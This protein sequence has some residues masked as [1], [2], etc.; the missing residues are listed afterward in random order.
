M[1]GYKLSEGSLSRGADQ[2][3]PRT[4][5][6][7]AA[8]HL[9]FMA[10]LLVTCG[11]K[12]AFAQQ[13]ELV[14]IPQP[15]RDA[16][17]R[18]PS[19]EVR[20]KES[21][22]IHEFVDP[23]LILYIDPARSRIVHTKQP[24]TR[25]VITDPTVLDVNQFGP[26]EFELIGR[27]SGETTLSLWFVDQD[28]SESLLRYVVR[29][30]P[31][32][33]EQQRADIEYG[34]LQDRLNELF[35]NSQIQLIPVADKLIVRGQV[36]DSEEAARIIAV[37]S[38]EAID[39]YGGY[40]PGFG[41]AN[42]ARLPGAEDLPSAQVI[43]LLIVPGE[44]QV[45]L[46]VR[47]AELSRSALRELGMDFEIIQDTF[48]IQH[49][50]GGAG[51]LTAIL[52]SG[53]VSLFIRAFSS[54]GYSKILAEPTLVTLSGHTAR[55]LAGGE[56]AVPTAVGIDGIAAAS[57]SFRGF[58]TQL[59][60]TPTVLDKDRIR[61][62]VAPSFSALNQDNSVDGIPGLDTRAVS[63]TVDLREGQW[64]AIAGLI[65]DEQQGSH[66][67][68]P[69]LG[70]IP[71]LGA[72]FGSQKVLRGETELVVLVSPELVH[73]LEAEQ[74]PLM[75]PGMELMDPTDHDFYL[76][77]KIEGRP[78]YAHRSTVWPSYRHRRREANSRAVHEAKAQIKMH[79]MFNRHQKYYLS[80]AG[81]FSR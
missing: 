74:V 78:D 51:N 35:P 4:T 42:A 48:A 64:L 39:Q 47:I 75:L 49:V 16:A 36:R 67:R 17:L 19:Q 31:D 41:G 30:A 34:Q 56:F 66:A 52:D 38:D 9:A 50:I 5:V 79:S 57:T 7:T 3:G 46:K 71:I 11:G 27:R 1:V 80:G 6:R 70:D 72:A 77:Q 59:S 43:N 29:V 37:V 76:L 44:Q 2:G 15:D 53:D 65:Q 58:G 73:P 81:G 55:F 8:R 13:P 63:T 24:V 54:N 68:F 33:A 23:E 20:A 10:L 26:A 40:L 21:R 28:G 18:S 60:F 25:I 69:L 45:M 14:P 62:H 61:L 22:L 32:Q 12:L